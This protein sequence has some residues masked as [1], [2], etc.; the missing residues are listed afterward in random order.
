MKANENTEP[1]ASTLI[2]L[3]DHPEALKAITDRLK[4]QEMGPADWIR[5][6]HE[7]KAWLETSGDLK[8]AQA[9]VQRARARR[10]LQETQALTQKMTERQERGQRMSQ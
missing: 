1:T 9:I 6:K 2:T 3:R 4:V 7:V 10:T 5:T 8:E